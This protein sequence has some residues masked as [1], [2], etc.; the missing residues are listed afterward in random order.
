MRDA[1][2]EGADCAALSAAAAQ[3]D[4]VVA[5]EGPDLHLIAAC[6]PPVLA[7]PPPDARW[8]LDGEGA[9]APWHAHVTVLRRA[10]G[11]DWSAPVAEAREM[12][13]KMAAGRG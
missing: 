10:P 2:G 8:P 3:M 13:A 6:G 12:L 11:A 1:V 5:A 4:A 7:L 9:D